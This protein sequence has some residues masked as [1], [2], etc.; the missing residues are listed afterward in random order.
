MNCIIRKRL[1]G[2]FTALGLFFL[3]LTAWAEVVVLHTNDIHCGVA[4][5][6]HIAQLA[7]YKHDLMKKNPNVLLV[8]AGDAIQGEPLGSL[9]EGAAI[10]RIMNSVGYDFAIPGN[11]EYD[12]GMTRFL[13][14]APQQKCGY[15]SCNFLDKRTGNPL[16]PSYKIFTLDGKKIAFV[17]V[18]TPETLISSTPVFFQNDEGKFI[19]TFCEDKDGT[20][21][22]AHIQAAVDEARAEGAQFVILVGHLGTNGA[23]SAWSSGAVAS[24]TTGINAIIDGHSHEQYSRVDKNKNGKDVIVAQTGTKLATVGKIVI[25]DD[26]TL[27]SELVRELPPPDPAVKAI[28]DEEL[29]KVDETL[30]QPVGRMEVTLETDI[31]SVRRVRCGETNLGDFV[32]D[33]VRATLHTDVALVNGGSFRAPIPEGTVTYKSLATTFPFSNTL[34]VRSI[35]GAQLL[36]ALEL[37]AMNYPEENGGFM[38][39]SGLTYTIDARIP[40]SVKL[41][42][43]GG[44]VEVAG[45]RRVKDVMVDGEPLDLTEDY[46]V[47]GTAYIMRNGGNGITM[48]DG[49][50][51]LRDTN[52]SD[53]DAIA[54]FIKENSGVIGEGYENP[55]GEGRITI[56]TE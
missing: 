41:N 5:N 56:L 30:G 35:S 48:F 50:P 18:T 52:I 21:L 7:Q 28:V 3:P 38:Q 54:E 26:G 31:D 6:L 19:Y 39:V 47:S 1:V 44:F 43:Q 49:T 4:Q 22:Y 20:N 9:T 45:E 37:G 46:T 32:A 24:H 36:D 23:I 27:T 42:E 29:Q 17:G 10:I 14:L 15:Y 11:H 40:S 16:L 34:V 2:L 53:L 51:I 33:A 25:H 8:D 55:T 13:E 12:F